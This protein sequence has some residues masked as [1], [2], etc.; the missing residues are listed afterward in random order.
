MA[1]NGRLLYEKGDYLLSKTWIE[2]AINNG[3]PEKF[4]EEWLGD[5]LLKTGDI[6]QAKTHWLKAKSLGNNS[7]R[8]SEKLK[9]L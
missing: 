4:G 1:I 6:Q 9:K 5:C 8:L 7:V 3:Y 2:K